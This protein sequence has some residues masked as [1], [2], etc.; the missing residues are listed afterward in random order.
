MKTPRSKKKRPQFRLDS[1][2]TRSARGQLLH[3]IETIGYKAT[4]VRAELLGITTTPATLKRWHGTQDA[5][6]RAVLLNGISVT[7]QI[8]SLTQ[9]WTQDS[10]IETVAHAK[11]PDFD[12]FISNLPLPPDAKI[13]DQIVIEVRKV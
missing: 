6:G 5:E 11:S 4:A 12:L 9:H 1:Q 13:G 3:W 10:K 2:L 7:A 8:Y